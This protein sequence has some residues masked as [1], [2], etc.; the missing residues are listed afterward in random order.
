MSRSNCLKLFFNR[1]FK[2]TSHF[3]KKKLFGLIPLESG[4]GY[5]LKW[6]MSHYIPKTW[7]LLAEFA[8]LSLD[9]YSFIFTMGYVEPKW[10]MFW[11]LG[12]FLIS[13]KTT[14]TSVMSVE[15]SMATS[16]ARKLVDKTHHAIL[17]ALF[18]NVIMIPLQMSFLDRFYHYEWDMFQ[19]ITGA[20]LPAEPHL[21]PECLSFTRWRDT[22]N[23][24]VFAYMLIRYLFR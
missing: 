11:F 20:E 24:L 19:R 1:L 5:S 21:L 10:G 14:F 13:A 7:L 23:F 16:R 9:A 8:L 15:T 22:I 17:I 4:K 6:L 3:V 12:V 18:H 2:E